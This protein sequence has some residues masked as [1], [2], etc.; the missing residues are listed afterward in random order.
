MGQILFG[1]NINEKIRGVSQSSDA[2][3]SPSD[4]SISLPGHLLGSSYPT[5]EEK[6]VY[7]TASANCAKTKG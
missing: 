5:E 3:A 4:A 2:G 6:L 7:S 1:S